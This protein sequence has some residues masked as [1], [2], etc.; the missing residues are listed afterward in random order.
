MNL[1][2]TDLEYERPFLYPK[3][4]EAF[5]ND[6]RYG[7]TEASTKA[8]K[9]LGA[10]IWLYEQALNADAE[11]LNNY[12]WVAPTYMQAAIAYTRYMHSIPKNMI[13]KHNINEFIQLNNGAVISFKTGEKPDNLF[14]DD[15]RAAVQDEASRQREEAF[16]AIR[17]TLTATNGLYRGIGNVK[18]RGNWFFKMCRKAEG[19]EPNMHYAMITAA[20]AARAGVISWAEIDDARATLPDAVFEELYMCKPA[21]TANNPFGYDN[22][23]ICTMTDGVSGDALSHK[24]P[25]AWGWDIAKSVD[26]TVGIGLDEDGRVCRYERFQLPYL[27]TKAQIIDIVGD[28]PYL[29]D[30]TGAG[31]PFVEILQEAHGSQCEGFTFTASSKQE[32][33]EGLA[34]A[35]KQHLIKFP[36]GAIVT[37][38]EQFE[39]KHS[40][41]GVRYSAPDGFHDDCVCG[42]ALAWR[43]YL[44]IKHSNNLFI[45]FL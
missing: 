1:Q 32:L 26:W 11:L 10:M 35:I 39:W 4:E 20:D 28:V 33:M 44:Q 13:L 19:G 31:N 27:G 25:V 41:T 30:A 12:W 36:D 37:E 3:Q 22:I 45:G 42:L 38:L 40:P 21:D 7:V 15:V 18:G 14:G 2:K 29:I 34:A 8:G 16:F 9:T 23:A 6:E 5:F 24:E 17:S 43:K